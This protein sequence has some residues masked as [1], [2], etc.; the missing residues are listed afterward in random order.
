MPKPTD[1]C[2]RLARFCL[3]LK[4]V[5]EAFDP[6][7]FAVPRFDKLAARTAVDFPPLL[8]VS[9]GYALTG[10]NL[11]QVVKNRSAVL[12]SRIELIAEPPKVIRHD[13]DA[14]R[15]EPAQVGEEME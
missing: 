6:V 13:E 11:D 10:K 15:K 14:P 9:R 1:S 5:N 3:Q 7:V 2:R 4:Q 8:V 12:S